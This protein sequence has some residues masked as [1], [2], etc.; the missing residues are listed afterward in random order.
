MGDDRSAMYEGWNKDRAHS[1]EWHA[2][3]QSFLQH[4]FSV[5][6]GTVV[7]CPCKKCEN[8]VCREKHEIEEHLCKRG[9][10]PNY[11]VW[12]RHRELLSR[13]NVVPEHDAGHQDTTNNRMD[14]MLN[15]LGRGI[16]FDVEE[17]QGRVP[18]YVEEYFR[19]LEAGDEKL[20]DHT[21]MTL[22]ET[23]SELMALKSKHNVSNNYYND[24]VK[25]M[26]KVLPNN[27]KLSKNLYRTKKMLA[28]LGM[29]YEKIDVCPNNCMLFW[30]EDAGIA[31]SRDIFRL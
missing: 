12:R 8:R 4:A 21:D 31:R 20:H 25:L 28:G 1:K 6:A 15:D 16:D 5:A 14:D 3:A 13:R 18:L 22:L 9:F 30:K 26:D 27:H 24:L 2:V 17:Q 29:K 23:V 11:L 19:L 7:P 10:M